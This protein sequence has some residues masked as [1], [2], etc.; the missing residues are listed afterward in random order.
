WRDTGLSARAE[1]QTHSPDRTRPFRAAREG[2]LECARRKRGRSLQHQGTLAQH[3]W[4]RAP[5]AYELLR[6]RQYQILWRSVVPSARAGFRRNQTP[7]R[8]LTRMADF[9]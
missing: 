7:W 6:R 3:R 4:H 8:R 1:W 5:S 9:V 2:E